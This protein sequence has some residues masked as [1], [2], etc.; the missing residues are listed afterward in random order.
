MYNT[1]LL[2][3]SGEALGDNNGPYNFDMLN[4]LAVQIK[5]LVS[6]GVKVGI[7]CGGGNICRGRTF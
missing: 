4:S 7:V 6:K 5:A 1:V 2:K 3:L